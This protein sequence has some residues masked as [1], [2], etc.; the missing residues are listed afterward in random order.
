M[1]LLATSTYHLLFKL[2]HKEAPAATA[3]A[4]TTEILNIVVSELSIYST[5]FI[6]IAAELCDQQQQ[7]IPNFVSGQHLRQVFIWSITNI[8]IAIICVGFKDITIMRAISLLYGI[9]LVAV[10]FMVGA[11]SQKAPRRDET[12]SCYYL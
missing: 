8:I 3:A 10:I 5:L 9:L 12:V 7:Q 6:A 11:Q 4:A 1:C 2:D